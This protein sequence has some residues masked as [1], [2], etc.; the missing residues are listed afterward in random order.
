MNFLVL[1]SLR[2][3]TRQKRRNFMLGLSIAIGVMI[4]VVANSFTGGISDVLFNR[5]VRYVTGQVS[6]SVYEKN[7]M[8]CQIFRDKERL[9]DLVD[10]KNPRITKIEESVG[11]FGRAIGNGKAENV[12]LIGIDTSLKQTEKER[13]ELEASFKM[14]D[15]SFQDLQRTDVENP[16]I[17]STD[18]MKD[19]NV[20]VNDIV[21]VR[22]K[23]IFG[24]DQAARITVVG[25]LKIT[26]IFM[27]GVMFLDLQNAKKLFGYQP[28]E[29]GPLVITMVN[30]KK[31]AVPVA[32][33][34]H[35]RLKPGIAQ[36]AAEIQFGGKQE[37]ADVFGFFN[38]EETKKGLEENVV[39]V[40]RQ[41][42]N[43][44][45]K[46]S[47][48]VG[49]VLAK[50]LNINVGDK[51]RL[52]YPLKFKSEK[53]IGEFT[54]TGTFQSAMDHGILMNE[55]VFYDMYYENLPANPADVPG[56]FK[57]T[58]SD[59]LYPLLATEWVLLP[60]TM[61]TDDFKKK[62]HQLTSKK[63]KAM[64]VDVTTMYEIASDI[65]QLEGALNLITIVAVFIL[66]L[67]IL[68]GVVNTLR[69]TVRERTREI[70]TMRA[71][72][73]Q[74]NDVRNAFILETFFLAIFSSA[75]GVAAAFAVMGALSRL[76][77][78][79]QDNPMGMFLVDGHIYFLPTALGIASNVLLILLIAVATAYFPAR[80]AANLKAAVAFRHYE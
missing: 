29:S 15:G 36:I 48:L 50:K 53:F 71:I 21:R 70:G 76:P 5:V 60:R 1:I 64:V 40:S 72:G 20:K 35:S 7:M 22:F 31:D 43:A 65:L 74:K 59:P 57:L 63:T 75:I 42:K 25:T 61:K 69:M 47:V 45:D 10:Q 62:M 49:E 3:L 80:R 38:K 54:V 11:I 33:Q 37:R 9:M 34:I 39:L 79:L 23:N 17:L 30:P 68:M 24:Q 41:E 16:V 26:N 52:S 56:S 67:I 55:Y 19:L 66:F 4:L 13:K 77:L 51:I 58:S 18:K 73:M 78:D 32:N 27:S 12:M 46:K 6:V 8:W 14:I 44:L 2:N 28:W